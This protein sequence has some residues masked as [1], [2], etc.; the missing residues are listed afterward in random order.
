MATAETEESGV[1]KIGLSVALLGLVAMGVTGG[2]WWSTG[3][4]TLHVL[5]L[6]SQVVVISLVIWQACDP[7]AE[8]AQWIGMKF[9]IPGSVRGATLDAVASS[10]PE[11]F[12]G[13][14]FVLLAI[15]A[16]GDSA[17]ALKDAGSTGY[18]PTVATCAGSA[19]YNMILIPAICALVISFSRKSRPTIDIAT[20]VIL[21]DGMWFLGCELLLI[22]FLFQNQMHWWMGVVL[23]VLYVLYVRRLYADASR[24]RRAI[25]AVGE[26]LG[27]KIRDLQTSQIEEALIANGIRPTVALVDEVHARLLARAGREV[28]DLEEEDEEEEPDAAGIL[29]GLFEVPL[30]TWTAWVVIGVCTIVAAASCYWLVEVTREAAITMDVPIFFIAVIVAAAASSV[31]D[32]FLSIGASRRGDDDGAVANAFGSNIFDICVCLAIPLLVGCYLSGWQ[33]IYLVDE[34][35]NPMAGL[36]G[37]RVLLLVLTVI[38]L[39]IMWHNQQLTRGKAFILCGLYGVFVLYAVAGSLGYGVEQLFQSP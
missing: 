37:I 24:F 11:L 6:L 28:E 25:H 3:G 16:A 5:F 34:S 10:M 1:D 38:T 2:L 19:I 22:I 39:L 4:T 27:D 18:G 15:F 12:T 21:R 23:L 8:A 36:V 29:F 35:G 17:E 30:S 14:F 13:I 26:H 33:P 9:H 20:I 32:T 7:F 31:P